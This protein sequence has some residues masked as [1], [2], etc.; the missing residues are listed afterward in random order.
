MKPSQ[1]FM[2]TKSSVIDFGTLEAGVVN[3]ILSKPSFLSSSQNLN[4]GCLLNSVQL[5]IGVRAIND[6]AIDYGLHGTIHRPC[7]FE[8]NFRDRLHSRQRIT[9]TSVHPVWSIHATYQKDGK[10]LPSAPHAF[11]FLR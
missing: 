6:E 8:E 3:V 7:T 2:G 9:I 4:V 1:Y 5:T 11:L 10:H